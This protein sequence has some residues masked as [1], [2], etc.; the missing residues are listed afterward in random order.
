MIFKDKSLQIIGLGYIGLPTMIFLSRGF[1]KTIGVDSNKN[2]LNQIQQYEVDGNEPN[3]KENLLDAFQENDITLSNSVSKADV[4]MI[5][6][7]TPIKF[8]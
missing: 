2:R 6:V 8:Q 7:P 3:L 4:H 5:C 1:K